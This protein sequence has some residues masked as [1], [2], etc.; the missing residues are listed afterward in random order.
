MISENQK[1]FLYSSSILQRSVQ[2]I[3]IYVD[4]YVLPP[5]CQSAHQKEDQTQ[6]DAKMRKYSILCWKC[7]HSA[8]NSKYLK[9]LQLNHC[10]RLQNG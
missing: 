6:E 3:F 5:E 2:Y 7:A 1:V 8:S 9:S 4:F 10:H